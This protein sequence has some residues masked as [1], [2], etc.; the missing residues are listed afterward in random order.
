[1]AIDISTLDTPFSIKVSQLIERCNEQN[2][3]MVPYYGIRT[4]EAQARLWRQSRHRDEINSK[5]E[6]LRS[7]KCDYLA[8][9][10]ESVGIVPMG[11]WATNAIPGL[12]WHNWGQA[13]DCYT[14]IDGK[15]SWKSSD[16]GFYGR[17]ATQ[18]Q[19]KWGGDFSMPDPGHVQLNEKEILD[20]YSIK[21]VNDYWK[22]KCPNL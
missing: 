18:L 4:L 5:I 16:Y 17:I 2:V 9:V 20:I 14:I 13:V 15:A 3:T 12:S 10:I 21:Y 6:K 11:R 1:M 19:L 7:L 8:D 22:E